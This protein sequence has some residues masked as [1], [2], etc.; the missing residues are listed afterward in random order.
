VISKVFIGDFPFQAVPPHSRLL[1]S[2][3]PS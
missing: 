2:F 3:D 1:G